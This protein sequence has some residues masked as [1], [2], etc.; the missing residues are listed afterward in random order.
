MY[1]L[2][3]FTE[4]AQEKPSEFGD[5]IY[6]LDNHRI[7]IASCDRCARYRYFTVYVDGEVVA[8]RAK[9]GNAVRIAI[10]YLNEHNS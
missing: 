9:M 4:N 2:K 3:Y 1:N 6:D 10:A 8:T 7:A 5:K